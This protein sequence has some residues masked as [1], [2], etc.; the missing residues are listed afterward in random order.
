MKKHQKIL[1]AIKEMRV[2]KRDEL[3][4]LPPTDFLPVDQ[5]AVRQNQL[6]GEHGDKLKT[7]IDLLEELIVMIQ[8]MVSEE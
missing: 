1:A 7:E 3:D 5:D 8:E 4:E 2:S 6:N